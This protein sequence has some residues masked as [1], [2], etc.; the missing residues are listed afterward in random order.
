MNNTNVVQYMHRA[1]I[2][3]EKGMNNGEF[4]IGALIVHDGNILA[5]N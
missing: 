1:I 3:A 4:P 5:E 2:M